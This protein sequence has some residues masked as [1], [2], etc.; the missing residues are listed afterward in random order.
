MYG[1]A[2]KAVQLQCKA[3]TEFE[4]LVEKAMR[5]DTDALG[6]LCEKIAK[7]VLFQVVVL[8]GDFTDAEDVSQN[9]FVC[10]CK[11]IRSLKSSKAFKVWLTRIIINEK[12]NYVRE[13]MRRGTLLNIDDYLESIAEENS[14]VLPQGYTED[15]ELCSRVTEAIS[16]LPLRQRESTILYYYYGM[17]VTEIA[18]G[19]GITTQS[20]SKHLALA[21]SKLKY[22]LRGMTG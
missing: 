14:S 8:L 15:D 22:S 11:N 19:R 1:V 17:S 4:L 12:N 16:G 2:K 18:R 21:H 13:K 7:S 6:E 9:V 5:G 20:I 3:N 10:V